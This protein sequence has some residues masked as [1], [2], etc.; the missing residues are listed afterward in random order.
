MALAEIIAIASALIAVA[1]LV[2][3]ALIVRRQQ[4]MAFEGLKLSLDSDV[5]AW[6]R[7]AVDAIADAERFAASTGF[8]DDPKSAGR[9]QT[10]IA[11]HLSALADQGRFYFPNI[12]VGD[13]HGR[14]KWAAFRGHRPPI[15]H[16]IVF[17]HYAI[18][19]FDPRDADALGP[20]CA[21]LFRCRRLVVSEIQSA[22]DPRRRAKTFSELSE[23]K[24][25]SVGAS[26][27]EAAELAVELEALHPGV[28][29]EHSDRVD[30]HAAVR[31]AARA[32]SAS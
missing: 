20:M 29:E 6:G 9:E 21:L 26:I 4:T 31:A 30:I 19:K 28:L 25:D 11:L 8:A 10:R 16:A 17:A 13:D 14:D 24:Q 23:A 18:K 27:K 2:F 3:N 22:I 32:A 1:S 5:L 12:D 15:I 7:H